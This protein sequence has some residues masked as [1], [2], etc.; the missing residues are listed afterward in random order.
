MERETSLS[1]LNKVKAAQ[2]KQADDHPFAAA[3]RDMAGNQ[4]RQDALSDVGHVGLAAL[5]VGA[6]ARGLMGLY[7]LL[8]ER[9]TNTRSGPTAL[10]LP[11]PDPN[12]PIE[13]EEEG[14]D[15]LKMGFSISDYLPSLDGSDASTKAGIP[16]YNPAMVMTGVAGLGAGWKG[17]DMLLDKRRQSERE[18]ELEKA[19]QEFHAALMQQHGVKQSA[20]DPMVKVGEAL[21]ELYDTFEATFGTATEKQADWLNG[22]GAALG[23]YGTYAGLTGLLAGA[24]V[25]DKTRKRSRASIVQ[26]ALQRRERRKFQQQP[27]EI[28]AIPEPIAKIDSPSLRDEELDKAAS[29]NFYLQAVLSPL[30]FAS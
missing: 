7:N 11:Y 8:R 15:V 24:L 16:W 13:D 23:G 2:E 4:L 28:Y 5:G 14:P 3:V 26:K 1:I 20:D 18:Q 29:D 21:D 9:P 27:P 17:V 25:Y 22:A 6:G 10:P 12:A 30:P 19:R